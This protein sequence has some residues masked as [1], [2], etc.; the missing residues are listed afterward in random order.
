MTV[1]PTGVPDLCALT[2]GNSHGVF[3]PNTGN[4]EFYSID[5]AKYNPGS[6]TF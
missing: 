3:D 6:Y 5:M 4:Y 1:G 2:D